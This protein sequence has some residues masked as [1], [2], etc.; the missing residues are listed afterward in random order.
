MKCVLSIAG[1]DPTGGAGIS[2]DMK[3]I[4][5]NGAY[6]MSV[7]T[8]LVA[9]NTMGVRSILDVP[10]D[11][12]AEQLD[13]VFE[14][15]IPDAVKIGMTA[16]PEIIRVIAERLR[17]YKAQQIVLDPVMVATAGS[18]LT[19]DDAVVE[20]TRTLLPLCTVAT[21][22]IPEAEVLSEIKIENIDD[23]TAASEIISRRFGCAV[24]VKGGH[25]VSDAVDVLYAD[26]KITKFE[27]VRI[28]NPNTHG[29]GCTLSSAIA[30]NLAKNFSLEESVSRAK[31]YVEAALGQMLDLGH[32]SGPL[33]HNF[34]TQGS[35]AKEKSV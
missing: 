19:S 12:L 20:M 3:T 4:A 14:D 29:T 6:A 35:F 28:N 24:L 33:M 9:Q 27:G 7:V 21:P 13:S 25:S 11:F 5:A 34:N 8:S 31:S 17:F 10:T 1:T 22:N 30:T 26:G 18:S 16:S 32:G 23:M 2:A 15:I